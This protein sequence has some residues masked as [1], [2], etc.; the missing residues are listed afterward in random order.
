MTKRDGWTR[1]VGES[2]D[3]RASSGHYRLYWGLGRAETGE[4]LVVLWPDGT[5]TVRP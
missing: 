1:W 5:R 2:E 4:R 3:S